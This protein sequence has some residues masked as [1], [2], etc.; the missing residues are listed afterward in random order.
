MPGDHS[1][2]F[3]GQGDNTPYV[4]TWMME[5]NTVRKEF[6][7]TEA[8]H[9]TLLEACRPQ[10]YL[11]ANGMEPDVVGSALR[12]WDALGAELGFVGDTVR[13]VSGKSDYF[14]TATSTK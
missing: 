10:M 9:A 14:F 5:M 4:P 11:V 2:Q 12:A 7:L 3:E 13:P 8:Q 6:E 1:E